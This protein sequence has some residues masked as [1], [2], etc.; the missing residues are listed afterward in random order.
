MSILQPP[1]AP[2]IAPTVPDMPD[3]PSKAMGNYGS[4]SNNT[5]N[6]KGSLYSLD[7][8]TLF[9]IRGLPTF[10][11]KRRRTQQPAF[12]DV[13][14][15]SL[16]EPANIRQNVFGTVTKRKAD[17]RIATN[18]ES[19]NISDNNGS[20]SLELTRIK[21]RCTEDIAQFPV[22]GAEDTKTVT[23]GDTTIIPTRSMESLK[24]HDDNNIDDGSTSLEGWQ[25]PTGRA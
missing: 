11:N 1:P 9:N 13:P 18:M 24:L 19:H 8:T 16:P 15:L 17:T 22:P 20:G 23:F 6:N 2:I 12:E 4:S 25:R 7:D 14:D 3:A 5:R 21:R 10:P